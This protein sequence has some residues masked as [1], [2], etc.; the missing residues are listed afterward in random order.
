MANEIRSTIVG[1]FAN[2]AAARTVVDDLAKAGFDRSNIHISTRD[3]V[4]RQVGGGGAGLG[5]RPR[6]ETTGGGIT[7]WFHGLFGSDASQAEKERY[8][9]A[10]NRGRCVVAVESTQAKIDQAAQIMERDGAV[11]VEEGERTGAA[12]RRESAPNESRSVPVIEEEMQVGKRRILRGGVRVY[13]RSEE[14]PVEKDVRLTEE[15]V[16]LERRPAD[17]PATEADMN[18]LRDQKIEVTESAEEPVVQ[19]QRRVVEDVVVG[20]ERQERTETVRDKV[21]HTEVEVERLGSSE[22]GARG[23]RATIGDTD[24]RTDFEQRFAGRGYT[25]DDI[26]PAYEYG[27]V[28]ATDPEL[29]GRSFAEVEQRLKN[30]Y[31]RQHPDERWDR[32][33]DAVR[34]GWETKAGRR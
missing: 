2:E 27:R 14:R 29:H 21:L 9:A 33:R 13:T 17:R 19:K 8:A 4:A 7:G 5:G 32:I 22:K 25:Y 30:D 1:V 6:P 11:D 23:E 31:A 28:K 26:A 18:A 34:Y 12:E 24:F 10:V 16:R 3:E 15:K 20:K